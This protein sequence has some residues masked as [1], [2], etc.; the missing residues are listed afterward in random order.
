MLQQIQ[1][2]TS[3]RALHII[4]LRNDDT[5]VW[6]MRET[7]RFVIDTLSHFPEMKLEWLAV[8]D[9]DHVERIVRWKEPPRE[10][11]GKSRKGKEKA[12]P[13]TIS[14]GDSSHFPVLSLDHPEAVSDSD[15]DYGNGSEEGVSRIETIDS[16][17]FY[18]VW[19]VRIFKREIMSG[20][21]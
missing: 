16:I 9:D 8:D 11:K 2:L 20:R 1:Q 21:L 17:H 10:K 12:H 15:E 19:G 13:T 18:D 6:V 14:N 4:N 3:L 7:K 5:C